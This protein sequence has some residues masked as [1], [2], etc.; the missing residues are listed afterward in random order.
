MNSLEAQRVLAVL[1]DAVDSLRQA[2]LLA[3]KSRLVPNNP[4]HEQPHMMSAGLFPSLLMRSWLL[5]TS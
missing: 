2:L 4:T 3:V 5:L 1:D